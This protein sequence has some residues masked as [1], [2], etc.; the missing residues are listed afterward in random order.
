MPNIFNRSQHSTS[1]TNNQPTINIV[2]VVFFVFVFGC[3]PSRSL[4]SLL[5]AFSALSLSLALVFSWHLKI[6][7]KKE[8]TKFVK[9]N[10]EKNNEILFF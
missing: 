9:K 3:S 6:V 2:V 10:L 5:S 4:F 7:E 1:A 8:E